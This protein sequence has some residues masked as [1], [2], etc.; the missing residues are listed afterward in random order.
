MFSELIFVELL[1]Y[2]AGVQLPAV[3]KDDS[4][5]KTE[6]SQLEVWNL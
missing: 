3:V 4:G 1:K 2:V 5:A 6:L